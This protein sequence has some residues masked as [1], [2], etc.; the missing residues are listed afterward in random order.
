QVIFREENG[1]FFVRN[2]RNLIVHGTDKEAMLRFLR[3]SK[4]IDGKKYFDWDLALDSMFHHFYD[5]NPNDIG[6]IRQYLSTPHWDHHEI[7][8]KLLRSTTSSLCRD[9][10]LEHLKGENHASHHY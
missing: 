6:L 5:I 4:I 9:Y 2:G 7:A 10:L 1:F 8:K 3:S